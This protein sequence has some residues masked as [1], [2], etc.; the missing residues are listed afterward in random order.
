MPMGHVPIFG[1]FGDLTLTRLIA[2]KCRVAPMK[3]TIVRIELAGALLAS[4][5]LPF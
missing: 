2:A 3:A 1:G 5:C 4:D